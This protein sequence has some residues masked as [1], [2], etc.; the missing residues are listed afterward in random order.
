MMTKEQHIAYW[1]NTAEDDW[2][3]VDVIFNFQDGIPTTTI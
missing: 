3:A 2:G 1:V